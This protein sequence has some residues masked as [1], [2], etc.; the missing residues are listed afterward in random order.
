MDDYRLVAILGQE[1]A[2]NVLSMRAFGLQLDKSPPC[3]DGVTLLSAQ[4]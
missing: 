1:M 2:L 4:A 3:H